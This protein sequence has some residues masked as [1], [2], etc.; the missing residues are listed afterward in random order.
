MQKYIV[1]ATLALVLVGATLFIP[2]TVYSPAE[3]SAVALGYPFAFYIQDFSRYTPPSYPQSYRF[4]SPWEDPARIL[5]DRFLMSYFFL[6]IFIILLHQL[7]R[8]LTGMA[9]HG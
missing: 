3:Q 1:F 7:I 8:R 5:W 6:L 4:G 9:S 2:K